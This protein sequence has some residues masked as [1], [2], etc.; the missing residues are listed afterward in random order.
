M[1]ESTTDSLQLLPSWM[2]KAGSSALDFL[3]RVAIC[4]VLYFIIAKLLKRVLASLDRHLERRG[5]ASTV[6]HFMSALIK[7]LVLGFT[8]VTMIVQ[9]HL[10]E[11]SS[12]AALVASAG[13]GISLAAQGVLSNFAGGVLLLILKPFK[14]GDFITVKGEDV[15]GTVEKIELYYTTIYTPEREELVIPNST[16]TNKPVVNSGLSHGEKRLTIQIGISYREDVRRAM[17]ILDRLMEEEERILPYNRRTFVEEMGE[18]SVV[19]GL[20]CLVGIRDY[21]DVR[22]DMEEKIRLEF[23]KEKVEIPYNQLDVHLV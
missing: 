4:L 1:T 17:Q 16:L 13:V 2:E 15:Q 10:V 22:W 8:I 19:I 14:E 9:L 20:R 11:A 5:T 23:Q 7:V 12:I 21:L 18:S 6:R 3:I